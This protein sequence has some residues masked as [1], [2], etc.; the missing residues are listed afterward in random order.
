M[1]YAFYIVC[2][3]VVLVACKKDKFETKPSLTLK[4]TSSK[5]IPHNGSFNIIF[6]FTDKE[7]DLKDSLFYRKVRLNVRKTTEKPDSLYYKIPA[8]PKSTQGEFNVNIT[9]TDLEAAQNPLNIPNTNPVQK[10]SDTLDL[11][12]AIRDK[13]KHT[14]DTV[15]IKG[16]VVKRS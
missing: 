2:L 16:V 6:E 5:I 9:Y 7:G 4:S 1:K 3:L 14:S 15:V 10:E 12:F 11:K 13:E 8:F